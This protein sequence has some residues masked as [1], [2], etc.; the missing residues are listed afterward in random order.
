M[1]AAPGDDGAACFHWQWG[2]SR[3]ETKCAD[4][5]FVDSAGGLAVYFNIPQFNELSMELRQHAQLA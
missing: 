1:E 3:W 4:T 2:W 5:I